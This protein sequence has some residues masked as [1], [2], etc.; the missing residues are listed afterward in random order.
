VGIDHLV[1]GITTPWLDPFH[2]NQP[3]PEPNL[4]APSRARRALSL[5]T[6]AP[7]LLPLSQ[8]QEL[9]QDQWELLHARAGFVDQEAAPAINDDWEQPACPSGRNSATR[10]R[11]V[12][13]RVLVVD[14]IEGKRG[15]G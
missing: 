4:I 5:N 10:E 2:H 13:S 7:S 8:E 15:P 11:A 12:R 1:S 14:G 6:A 9:S 3:P